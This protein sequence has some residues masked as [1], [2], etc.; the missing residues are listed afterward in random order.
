M[1]TKE[2][3]KKEVDQLPESLLDE[4]H[5]LMKQLTVVD[6]KKNRMDFTLRHFK[7]ILDNTDIRIAAYEQST[8]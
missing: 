6:K 5:I 4:P 7:G 2:E 3:L 8:G 1:I